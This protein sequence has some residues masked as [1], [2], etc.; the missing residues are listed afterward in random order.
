MNTEV[1]ILLAEDTLSDAEMTIRAIRKSKIENR[2]I[3]VKDGKE[4]MDFLSG[5]GAYAGRNI[6]HKP[7]VV[8]LDL[9][10]PRLNG[11]EVLEL[12][13]KNEFLRDISVVV[14]TSSKEDPDIERC[15]A[16]GV[17]SY[18]VKPVDYEEFM[19]VVSDLVLYWMLHNQ[20]PS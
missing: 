2:I 20:S 6:N 1:E 17:N 10:M 11:M 8:L 15:Y 9:K 12:I 4:A 7:K 5:V 13:R 16:L 18:I 14:L 19:K 3:H